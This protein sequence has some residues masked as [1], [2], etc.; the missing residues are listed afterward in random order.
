MSPIQVV[1]AVIWRDGRLLLGQ[2]PASRSA[3]GQ[4]E[5]PGGKVQGG[6]T[7]EGALVRELAEELGVTARVGELIAETVIDSEP[8]GALHLA[9]Y[10]VEI[11]GEPAAHHHQALRW[12]LPSELEALDLM[13]GDR[14]FA[15][16]LGDQEVTPPRSGVEP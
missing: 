15:R 4:W 12:V 13:P 6:E 14:A 7:P 1:A 9:F 2:R 5:F 8:A 10:A 11:A 16:R 3:P